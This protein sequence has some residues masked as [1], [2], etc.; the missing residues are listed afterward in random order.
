MPWKSILGAA[1]FLAATFLAAPAVAGADDYV[2]EPVN[3]EI[4]SSNGRRASGAQAQRKAR[5]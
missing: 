3:A 2:F 5:H 1:A 4:K